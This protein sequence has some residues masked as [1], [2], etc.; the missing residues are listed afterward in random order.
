MSSHT[1]ELWKMCNAFVKSATRDRLDGVHALGHAE[2]VTLLAI[3]IINRQGCDR[4]QINPL[5]LCCLIVVAQIHDILDHKFP[6]PDD[7]QKLA[8]TNFLQGLGLEGLEG[9]DLT[10]TL[11]K[12]ADN[13]S[14]SKENN[15]ILAGTPIDFEKELNTPNLPYASDI[16]DTVSDADKLKAINFDGVERLEKWT[17]FAFYREHQREPTDVEL[18]RIMESHAKEKL[19]RLKDEFMRTK[20]GKEMAVTAHDNF[21]AGMKARWKT[22]L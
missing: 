22:S 21:V 17:R 16:R 11:M 14:Y 15:A 20:P 10:E 13:I 8:L 3:D 6:D 12:I 5:Y 7:C 4:V 1:A 2:E 18:Q 9:K 19:L